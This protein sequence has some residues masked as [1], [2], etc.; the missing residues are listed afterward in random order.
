MA[1]TRVTY[2]Q[3]STA[4]MSDL[5]WCRRSV[6]E[7]HLALRKS[8]SSKSLFQQIA[9]RSLDNSRRQ[10]NMPNGDY[11]EP[12]WAIVL[13]KKMEK[14]HIPNIYGINYLTI[15][16]A[17]SNY[18]V[19]HPLLPNQSE[20]D[21]A[22]EVERIM[23][24][25]S[26]QEYP[27][28]TSGLHTLPHHYQLRETNPITF[29]YQAMNGGECSTINRYDKNIQ[30]INKMY[31]WGSPTTSIRQFTT[32]F[33]P[34][35]QTSVGYDPSVLFSSSPS[36]MES[37]GSQQ[38]QSQPQQQ[39]ADVPPALPLRVQRS[40]NQKV[41]VPTKP[42]QLIPIPFEDRVHLDPNMV[43]YKPNAGINS[44]NNFD[45]NL[46][47]SISVQLNHKRNTFDLESHLDCSC[48]Y[49]RGEA[50]LWPA[51]VW[52]ER[53]FHTV[54]KCTCPHEEVHRF[55]DNA[56]SK[57]KLADTIAMLPIRE[58]DI[59]DDLIDSTS[60]E[61]ESLHR[62]L[63]SVIMESPTDTT[64]KTQIVTTNYND[65]DVTSTP[66]FSIPIS[67]NLNHI[68]SDMQKD[69]STYRTS[70]TCH[71]LV[72]NNSSSNISCDEDDLVP[73]GELLS[74]NSSQFMEQREYIP[75]VTKEI[76]STVAIPS[77]PSDTRC[78]DV[79][80]TNAIRR[81][82]PPGETSSQLRMTQITG[83]K[84]NIYK[85]RAKSIYH[86]SG[87]NHL[88]GKS[89]I[90]TEGTHTGNVLILNNLT[91]AGQND[92]GKSIQD[93]IDEDKAGQQKEERK[94][95]LSPSVHRFL[96]PDGCVYTEDKENAF[97]TFQ[98]DNVAEAL[99]RLHQ[100][101][102]SAIEGKFVDNSSS[103]TVNKEGSL[104]ISPKTDSCSKLL[105]RQNKHLYTKH[106]WTDEDK[107][108]SQN[109]ENH[110]IPDIEL[111]G[112]DN[113]TEH[114]QEIDVDHYFLQPRRSTLKLDDND[115]SA[116]RYTASHKST[117]NSF[118]GHVPSE[119]GEYND[120]SQNVSDNDEE[121]DV[122]AH[123]YED[124]RNSMVEENEELDQSME[125]KFNDELTDP[126]LSQKSGQTIR[127][128]KYG[129]A[130]ERWSLLRTHVGKVGRQVSDV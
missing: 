124:D 36:S 91:D 22:S 70:V 120:K 129:R 97:Q 128:N 45:D 26:Q 93:M 114:D 69:N 126:S 87:D 28:I 3:P 113:H 127:L 72:T 71:H 95:S 54:D 86:E 102:R 42:R 25:T 65:L 90:N 48:D 9:W 79:V 8:H 16:R 64:Y 107:E 27:V 130:K 17:M 75:G 125:Y 77:V 50:G 21:P 123:Y 51:D 49:V 104:T 112:E 23:C 1:G 56:P 106:D 60:D 55:F 109:K 33:H 2:A 122:G 94:Q 96:E 15:K 99:D 89:Y 34:S 78:L 57:W 31:P 67:T 41:T 66:P 18:P 108:F 84:D 40:T 68:Q 81:K 20:W 88:T 105:D 43:L 111:M 35:Y 38:P 46:S 80:T 7:R 53:N 103:S 10:K 76:V 37:S 58:T 6:D 5:L 63:P 119:N 62:S 59:L 32:T 12:L 110:L 117:S 47:Q 85:N 115:L 14:N 74:K 116:I 118:I 24:G 83:R 92:M 98:I 11:S 13:D 29:R 121:N 100:D 73:L 82:S 52:F 61:D 30:H 44:H 101:M 4:P 19:Y 39:S